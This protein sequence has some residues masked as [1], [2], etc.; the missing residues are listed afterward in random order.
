MS[1]TKTEYC[2]KCNTELTV[3]KYT[4]NWWKMQDRFFGHYLCGDC[5]FQFSKLFDKVRNHFYPSLDFMKPTWKLLFG[6]NHWAYEY[7]GLKKSVWSGSYTRL[8]DWHCIRAYKR[9]INK[10]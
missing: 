9:F 1:D 4:G 2:A 5:Y 6:C 7:L 8:Y 10:D 3:G